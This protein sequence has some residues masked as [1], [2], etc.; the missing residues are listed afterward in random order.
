MIILNLPTN[1]EKLSSGTLHNFKIVMKFIF[2]TFIIF[3]ISPVLISSAYSDMNL[4]ANPGFENDNIRLINW[5]FVTYSG[6]TTFWDTAAHSGARSV[7]MEIGGTR[8]KIS[9]KVKS[10]LIKANPVSNYT[11]SAWGK[12]KNANGTNAPAVR[13]AELDA[14]K[15]LIR[16]TNMFFNKGTNEW[17]QKTLDFQTLSNTAYLYIYANIFNGYGTFWVDDVKL[18]P[19]VPTMTFGSTV[20]SASYRY[21]GHWYGSIDEDGSK[22]EIDAMAE[23]GID[24]FRIDIRN[25]T[26]S[27]PEEVE[28]LDN[29]VAYGRSRGLKVYLGVFGM[30]TW[31]ASWLDMLF[32]H[33]FGGGGTASWYDFKNM[34]TYETSYLMNRYK[35][36]YIMI[37]VEARKNI[38]NQVNSERTVE[39]WVA[40][41]KELAAMIKSISPTTK[42]I[43]NEMIR[44]Q[45]ASSS[46]DYVERMM[47]DNDKNIDVIGIDPYSFDEFN[48]EIN[49]SKHLANQ[50]NWHGELW[51]G[52][53]NIL[54]TQGDEFQRAYF[55]YA[56]NRAEQNNFT[57]F[58]VFYLR[59]NPQTFGD[60]GIMW[61][62]F[63]KKPAYWVIENKTKLKIS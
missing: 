10:D 8:D 54:N 61:N 19:P 7:R 53:T 5:T 22:K 2:L 38:G 28:K 37:I 62:N 35:P 18:A 29:I 6:S 26:L 12:T 59:D 3:L 21:P 30:E 17:A 31:Q 45:D 41:T 43:I 39:E 42:I 49:T 57:G 4:I 52:E 9:G 11:L 50:Y 46:V 20:D 27:F 32:G 48:D 40:Y 23:M 25:E 1:K 51:V 16:Q 63:S 14:N 58:V 44:S 55:E 36:D 13:V 15:K 33:P 56:I 24:F 47:K 34:Y 60:K